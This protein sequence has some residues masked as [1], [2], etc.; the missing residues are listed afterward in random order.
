MLVLLLTGA[1][2]AKAQSAQ[3][4]FDDKYATELVKAGTAA[5]DFKMKTPDGKTLQLAQP[6]GLPLGC[7][8]LEVGGFRSLQNQLG[9]ILRVQVSCRCLLALGLCGHGSHQE[10]HGQ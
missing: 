5:P 9:C 10:Q 6:E 4:D 2:V 8:Q 7:L 1:T 3:S